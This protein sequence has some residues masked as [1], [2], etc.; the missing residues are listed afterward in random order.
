MSISLGTL[1]KAALVVLGIWFL[2]LV[3]EVLAILFL[4]IIIASAL[5]PLGEFFDRFYLPRAVSVLG[6]YLVLIGVVV[7]VFYLIIPPLINDLKEL[8]LV[9]PEYYETVSK[10]IFKTTRGIS[11]DYAKSAQE[12]LINFGD[13]IKGFTAGIFGAV[14]GIFGGVVAFGAILVIS[15][16]LAIQKKGVEEFLR[17]VTPEVNEEYV[18]NLWRRVEKKLSKWLQGQL[19]LAFVV[20]ILVFIGLSFIGVPYALLLGF[21]AAIFEILPIA[22]PVLSAV[23]GVSVAILVSPV[24][25]LFTVLFYIILQQVENHVL[26]PI[27]MKR[28]TG[29]NPVVVIVALLVGAKLGGVLGM[30]ISVPITTIAGEL[31]E[32]FAKQKSAHKKSGERA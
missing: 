29:L 13:K 14:S 10:Q 21:I 28:A 5:A 26:V 19:L 3:K 6:V 1:F 22:G 7:G 32:D 23:V 20:G 27:L 8:A 18:L 31:L 11:P 12:F 4:A 17:L 25:A 16:Y 24:L 15:F 30:L 9:V 2:F